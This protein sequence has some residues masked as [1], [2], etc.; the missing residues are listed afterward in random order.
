MSS[1][2]V[3]HGGVV[4]CI[5]L[6]M[7]KPMSTCEILKFLAGPSCQNPYYHSVIITTYSCLQWL[8]SSPASEERESSNRSHS[9]MLTGDGECGHWQLT[10]LRNKAML[11]T[12]LLLLFFL[13][14]TEVKFKQMLSG[15]FQTADLYVVKIWEHRISWH[16]RN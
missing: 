9:A 10:S 5:G 13:G 15:P 14:N 3:R 2:S 16:G 6:S 1:I 4:Y 12:E 11:F 7:S 8:L